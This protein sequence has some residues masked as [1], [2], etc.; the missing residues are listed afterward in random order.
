MGGITTCPKCSKLYTAGSEEEANDPNR[1]CNPC[2][3]FGE[4]KALIVKARVLLGAANEH[5][6]ATNQA[7]MAL[8]QTIEQ[9]RYTLER[10]LTHPRMTGGIA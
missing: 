10:V 8:L 7:S 1:E 4:A 3:E 6:V 2:T 5:L 9:C